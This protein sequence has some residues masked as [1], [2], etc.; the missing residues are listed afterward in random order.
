[1]VKILELNNLCYDKFQN[2]NMSFE[3]GKFYSIIGDN[4]SGKTTLFRLITGLISTDNCIKCDGV[5]FNKK[6]KIDYIK[7][8]G[9]VLRVN[10]DAF[11]YKMVHDEMVFPLY[12]LGYNKKNIYNQINKVLDIFNKRDILNKKINELSYEDKQLLLIM[13]SLL[14]DP[15]VLVFDGSLDV[16][17]RKKRE[18][19]IKVLLKLIKSD[20][21]TVINFTSCL[22]ETIYSNELILL[23]KYQIINN[24]QIN[25]VYSNDRLF[26]EHNLEIPFIIDLS[27]KLKMYDLV[28]KDYSNIKEMVDDLWH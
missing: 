18:M 6:N 20:N 17:S 9:V 2:I 27:N 16:F 4:N 15:K 22:D 8:I 12:N 1:M 3:C 11:V 7:K 24:Y 28:K 10:K 26:Y 25:E 23:S 21:I 19:I 13:I 14:H 5:F